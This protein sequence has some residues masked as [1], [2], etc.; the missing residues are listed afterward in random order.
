[1]ESVK[2]ARSEDNKKIVKLSVGN[3][4]ECIVPNS[5]RSHYPIA[6]TTWQV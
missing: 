2:N 1:M 4:G 3:A 5:I 6:L